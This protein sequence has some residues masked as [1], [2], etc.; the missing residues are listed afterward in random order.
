MSEVDR[1]AELIAQANT[2]AILENKDGRE[3]L[4]LPCSHEH[5][6]VSDPHGLLIRKP[7]YVRQDVV[8]ETVDSVVDYVQR[9]MTE[10][11][12]LL[13][14]MS[15]NRIVA[16]IDYHMPDHAEHVAHRAALALPFSEEWKLWTGLHG[17]MTDQ[18]TFARFLEENSA[19]VLTP[20]AGELLDAARDLHG[21]RKV[22]FIRVVRTASDN[23]TFEYADETEARTKGGIDLPSRFLISIPVYFDEPAREVQAF[24]R[25]R[26]D[27]GK[28]RLGFSLHRHEYVRQAEFKRIV[29]LIGDKTTC[30]IVYG[31]L[32]VSHGEAG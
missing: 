12:V 4:I 1:I 3:F 21:H 8:L 20:P 10:K 11:T 16:V 23:E 24:L 29:G 26:L 31:R 17:V 19:D 14:V 18:L 22:S 13:A 32:A 27:D 15:T 9:Y 5:I 30:P 25:W 28:L 6:E 2:S 7:L